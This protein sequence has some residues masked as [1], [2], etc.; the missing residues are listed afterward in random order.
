[1]GALP[2]ECAGFGDGIVIVYLDSWNPRDDS[3]NPRRRGLGILDRNNLKRI[4]TCLAGLKNVSFDGLE[5]FFLLR[6]RG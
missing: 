5:F 1:M 4:G 2:G 6:G 3:W